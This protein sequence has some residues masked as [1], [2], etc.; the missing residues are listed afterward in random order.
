MTVYTYDV[1]LNRTAKH[2][3]ASSSL[4]AIWQWIKSTLTRRRQ[5]SW[6]HDMRVDDVL[7]APFGY[8]RR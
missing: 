1:H 7:G 8:D 5:R 4:P 2:A 6:P 3:K